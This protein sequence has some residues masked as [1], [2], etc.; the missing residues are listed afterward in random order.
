M[1]NQEIIKKVSDY[2][3]KKIIENGVS[4]NGVDW[5]GK[6]SQY[7]RFEQLSKVLEWHLNSKI[8][9]IDFGCGYGEFINFLRTKNAEFAYFG[10]D[11]SEKMLEEA[12]KQH[13]QTNLQFFRKIEDCGERDFLIAS[14]VFNVRD[15]FSDADWKEYIEQNLQVFNQFAKKGFAFN[16]LTSYSDKPFMKDYLYYANPLYFFDYCKK[17]F[18]KNVALL[19]DYDLYEFTLLVR[20]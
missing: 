10:L 17:H 11:I 13:N 16:M 18:S 1:K 15:K 5:N 8:S 9:L 20:K 2:Y 4:A 12:R 19:H 7:L 6:E 3:T 14:G